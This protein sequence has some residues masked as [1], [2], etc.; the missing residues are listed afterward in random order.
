MSRW[1]K[2][3]SVILMVLLM[4][5]VFPA[6]AQTDANCPIFGTSPT[7]GAKYCISMPPAKRWNHDLVIFAHGYVSVTD[8]VDIPWDQMTFTDS[9][10]G[11]LYLPNIVNTLGYAFATTSY[12]E[13]GL[14]VQSGISDILDLEN[15]FN[16][17]IGTPPVHIY[18]VGASE[19]GLVTTLAIERYPNK[20]TGGMSMC[21]PIGSFRGQINYWGDFRTVF[22][23]FMD[24]PNFKV[25]PG[26]AVNIPPVLMNN[27][28]STY[29]PLVTSTL[30][31]KPASTQQLLAVTGAAVDPS[32]PN[33]VGETV[34]GLLWYNVFATNDGIAKLGGQ[35]FDNMTHVYS[36]SASDVLLNLGVKR[37]K[38]SPV[39][40]ANIATY[41][42]T[43]GKLSRPLVVMHTT[44]D[45][46]VPYWHETLY[47][48][49]V[50]SKLTPTLY[51]PIT[52][53][54]YGHCAFTLP[55]MITGFGSLVFMSTKI[56]LSTPMTAETAGAVPMYQY[57]H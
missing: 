29:V 36:G 21:G 46:I 12:R 37:Y 22:D 4:T 15:I 44:G 34:L 2:I 56:Q 23:Y 33:T 20:F 53:K 47:T 54:S 13:N 14:A 39:A 18:L 38:A 32:D 27:W 26:S 45:P 19:G 3:F 51:L 24:T 42:E 57:P 10:G 31:A 30:A 43:S 17:K 9:Q 48:A 16:S 8:P 41:Y 35:P 52:I 40:L 50:I 28:D 11:T 49:K 1:I 55:Q 25:L 7:T 6:L 5:P